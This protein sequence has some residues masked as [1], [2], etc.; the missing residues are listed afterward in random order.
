M[1][2]YIYIYIY[3]MYIIHV[4]IYI[5]IYI[6]VSLSLSIHIYIYILCIYIYT[7]IMYYDTLYQ[8]LKKN[9]PLFLLLRCKVKAH[10]KG[11]LFVHRHRYGLDSI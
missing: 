9:I 4:Y 2:I 5:Y 3:N 1:Y 6:Y 7:Y 8:C 11:M 10:V